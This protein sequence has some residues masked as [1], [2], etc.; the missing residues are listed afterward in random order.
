MK[1]KLRLPT[2]RQIENC[3]QNEHWGFGN[4]IL[5]KMC[6]D[7]FKHDKV[8]VILGKVIIIGRTYAA[9]VERRRNKNETVGNGDDF[10]IKTVAPTFRKSNLDKRLSELKNIKK[11]TADNLIKVLEVHHYLTTTLFSITKL[12]KRSFTS[13]YLHF[14]LPDHFFIY[15]SRVVTALRNF[16][17]KV[18]EELQSLTREK[19]IDNEY[20]KYFCKCF[21]L[22][23][24]LEKHFDT[25]LTNRQLDNLL[26]EVSNKK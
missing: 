15:D 18:S 24:K 2:T 21:D 22:K 23:Q 12:N 6:R 14:H 1:N 10:Y 13:K 8:D 9:A 5:Y 19:N 25:T 7:N 16:T 11:L 20:A 4:D 3:K 17:S 26:I